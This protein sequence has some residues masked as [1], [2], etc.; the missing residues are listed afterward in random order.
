MRENCKKITL[1]EQ[2][3]MYFNQY[4]EIYFLIVKSDINVLLKY[5]LTYGERAL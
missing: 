2:K 3:I 4:I 1:F 5:L